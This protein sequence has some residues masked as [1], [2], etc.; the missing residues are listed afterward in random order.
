MSHASFASCGES[1][2]T[3]KR[4]LSV[5]L[6]SPS[7]SSRCRASRTGVREMPSCDAMRFS[8]SGEPVRTR[9]AVISASRK[10]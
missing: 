7:F 2:E 3:V 8:D 6:T 5:R 4:A 10:S 9:K 1:C